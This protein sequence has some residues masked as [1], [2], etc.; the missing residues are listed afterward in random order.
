MKIQQERRG[1]DRYETGPPGGMV[2]PSAAPSR[3]G[4]GVGTRSTGFTEVCSVPKTVMPLTEC[5]HVQALICIQWR[6]TYSPFSF[7][8]VNPKGNQPWIFIGRTDADA[9]A[10]ILWPPD[11]NSQLVGKDLDAGKDWRQEEKRSTKGEMASPI[12]WRWVWANQRESLTDT[13]N[14]PANALLCTSKS[15]VYLVSYLRYFFYSP[16]SPPPPTFFFFFFFWATLCGLWDLCS[17][18]RDWTWAPWTGSWE[19]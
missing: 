14:I 15:I 3:A 18:V 11:A 19:P 17:P 4:S 5:Q 9:E 10:P 1:G 8:F 13:W 7:A 2:F 12:Q 16:P 6:V